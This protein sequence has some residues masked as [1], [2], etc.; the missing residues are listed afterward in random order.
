MVLPLEKFFGGFSVTAKVL[1]WVVQKYQ[2]PLI[3]VLYLCPVHPSW[4][5]EAPK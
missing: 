4:D 3:Y 2:P 1:F 5:N